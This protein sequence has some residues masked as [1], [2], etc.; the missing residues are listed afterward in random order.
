MASIAGTK[1]AS[2][3]PFH[4]IRN[5]SSP[6]ASVAPTIRDGS[7]PLSKPRGLLSSV[8]SFFGTFSFSSSCLVLASYFDSNAAIRSGQSKFSSGSHVLSSL[9]MIAVHR[10]YLEHSTY[11]EYPFHFSKYSIF[12]LRI[13]LSKTFSTENSSSS[14]SSSSLDLLPP[15]F[16]HV[17]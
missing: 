5:I 15:V 14:S 7:K 6:L 9:K 11:S 13:L 8:K 1:S 12:P 2:L 4:I 3:Q 10:K 16:V 17:S